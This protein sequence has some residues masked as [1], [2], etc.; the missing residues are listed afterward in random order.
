[1]R[2]REKVT[3]GGPIAGCD[4]AGSV[5]AKK[6]RVT[7]VVTIDVPA[8]LTVTELTPSGARPYRTLFA[9][10]FAVPATSCPW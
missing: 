7:D 8:S 4:A 1:M 3:V 2:Q 9:V 5:T 6:F 10:A